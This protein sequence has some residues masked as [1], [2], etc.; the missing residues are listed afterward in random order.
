MTINIDSCN[1]E[2]ALRAVV[3]HKANVGR[4]NTCSNKDIE[5]FVHNV[6]Q[7]FKPQIIT[8]RVYSVDC[9]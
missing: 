8:S 3:P 6:F 5:I 7:L 1:L 4:I 9:K 2:A